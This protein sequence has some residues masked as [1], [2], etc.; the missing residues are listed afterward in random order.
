MEWKDTGIILSARKHGE[1][2]LIIRAFTPSRGVHAG[3]VRASKKSRNIYQVGNIVELSWKA[4]LEEHLGNYICELKH[5]IA[6]YVLSDSARLIAMQSACT[7]VEQTMPE[8]DP[9]PELYYVMED[10]L[11]KLKQTNNQQ[12]TTNNHWLSSYILLEIELLRQL[13]YGLDLET[14]AATGTKED[15]AYISPKTGRAV[16]KEAGDPYKDK[17]FKYPNLDSAETSLEEIK[18]GLALTTHFLTKSLAEISHKTMPE[19]RTRLEEL[20]H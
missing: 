3:L 2:S 20:I 13:G 9:H 7:L 15:L 19:C 16:S 11:L 8:R 17:L 4:R 18:N 1:S 6:G 14:C 12:L 10:F 5:S